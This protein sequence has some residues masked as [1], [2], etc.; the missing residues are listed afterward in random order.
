MNGESGWEN[1]SRPQE[2][3]PKGQR[4]RPY[5]SVTHRHACHSG[6]NRSTDTRAMPHPNGMK[7][8]D[9]TMPT[10]SWAPGPK[11]RSH[12]NMTQQKPVPNQNPMSIPRRQAPTVFRP[13]PPLE[14]LPA[15]VTP[16]SAE[17]AATASGATG[18]Q[19]TGANARFSPAPA[20]SASAA[21]RT[22]SALGRPGRRNHRRRRVPASSTFATTGPTLEKI[23][24][25]TLSAPYTSR[26]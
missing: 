10:A 16:T 7:Y 14:A 22:A 5:S 18:H 4:E 2:K 9:S 25:H 8:S 17:K 24:G 26:V 11:T 12:W 21:S 13:P 15:A 3:P 6:A 20:S 23:C 1:A 19:P